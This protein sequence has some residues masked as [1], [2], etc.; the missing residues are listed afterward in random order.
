MLTIVDKGLWREQWKCPMA[1]HLQFSL[2]A[3]LFSFMRE[4]CVTWVCT[5]LQ[6]ESG[7]VPFLSSSHCSHRLPIHS[8]DE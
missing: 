6:T 2:L 5:R 7:L 4:L 8:A 3:L 1:R